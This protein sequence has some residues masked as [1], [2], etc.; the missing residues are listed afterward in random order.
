MAKRSCWEVVEAVLPHSRRLL[1]YGVSGTGKSY[2]GL[3]LEK[4]TGRPSYSVTLTEDTPML[5]LR[6]TYMPRPA[7]EG[8]TEFFWHNGAVSRA[9]EEG[10][11]LILNEIDAAGPDVVSY[12]MAVC[13]DPER[14][15]ITLPT[16]KTLKWHPE[17]RI[18]ATM[19]GD[20]DR[21]LRSALRD[22]FPTCIK[23][24]QVHPEAIQTLPADLRQAA[25]QAG[26]IEDDNRRISIRA[27]QEFAWLRRHIDAEVAATAV[28]GG[29]AQ[30][31]L[32][33][34]RI[35]RVPGA[36]ASQRNGAA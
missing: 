25:Q 32:N 27:W 17:G 3:A 12:L 24:D 29:R 21:D 2:T 35:S 10:A 14:D 8:G 13:G 30:E 31:A 28:F 6:G 22:R 16:G 7:K 19:N 34:L 5:E 1:L 20:P 4:V 23:V 26:I 18:L 33:A 11:V 15:F 9:M 36:A